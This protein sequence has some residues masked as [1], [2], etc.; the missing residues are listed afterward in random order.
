VLVFGSMGGD[1]QAGVHTQLLASIV[2]RGDDPA[3]AIG[4]PRWRVEPM[5]WHLRAETRMSDDVIDGLR[6]RG[7]EIAATS[8]YDWGMGH[9]HAIWPTGG[10]YGATFDPRSE[11][12]ALGR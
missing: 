4:A 6:A 3:D 8:S 7:H 2:D 9:A 1:A 11:G 10:G 12:A 5:T